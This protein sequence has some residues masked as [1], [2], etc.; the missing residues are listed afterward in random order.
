MFVHFGLRGNRI[1]EFGDSIVSLDLVSRL[2]FLL[3]KKCK[4][5]QLGKILM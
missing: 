1:S 5:C 4:G 3:T 2:S